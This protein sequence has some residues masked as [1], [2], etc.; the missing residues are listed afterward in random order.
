MAVHFDLRDDAPLFINQGLDKQLEMV[1]EKT[2]NEHAGHWS[3]VRR[4]PALHLTAI[5]SECRDSIFWAY[6]EVIAS[7]CR[8]CDLADIA[9]LGVP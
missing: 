3:V 9:I 2:E 5:S 7:E 8:D 1:F 6:I 4:L